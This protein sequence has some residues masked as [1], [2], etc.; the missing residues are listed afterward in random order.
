MNDAILT[1]RSLTPT[2][3]SVV[4]AEMHDGPK[5]RLHEMVLFLCVNTAWQSHRSLRFRAPQSKGYAA[6]PRGLIAQDRAALHCEGEGT[7]WRDHRFLEHRLLA[8]GPLSSASRGHP[9]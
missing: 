1:R 2:G 7:L 4:I 8:L 5:S 9:R 6:P 3:P